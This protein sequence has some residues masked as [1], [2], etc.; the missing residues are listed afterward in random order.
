M[1]NAAP[2][3]NIFSFFENV[4]QTTLCLNWMQDF[5]GISPLPIIKSK[6]AAISVRGVCLRQLQLCSSPPDLYL[7]A[8][9]EARVPELLAENAIIRL[10]LCQVRRKSLADERPRRWSSAR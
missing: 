8:G 5:P 1:K 6:G 7:R 2:K 9:E 4:P 10:V 3:P